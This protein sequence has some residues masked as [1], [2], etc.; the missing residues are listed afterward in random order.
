MS[1]LTNQFKALSERYM[2][3]NRILVELNPDN[4]EDMSIIALI[5]FKQEKMV[6]EMMA[7][8]KKL[9]AE[10]IGLKLVV[11]NSDIKYTDNNKERF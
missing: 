2:R 9:K 1:V 3:Y 11:S 10:K 6:T 7:L 4:K 5:N 8:Q